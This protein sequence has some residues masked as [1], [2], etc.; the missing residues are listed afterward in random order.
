MRDQN[1]NFLTICK[2]GLYYYNNKYVFNYTI[3]RD[4]SSRFSPNYKYG[5]FQS[6]Q[7]AWNAKEEAFLKNIR[8]IF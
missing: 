6:A 1:C 8:E 2:I 3:R 4:G 7:I 5:V